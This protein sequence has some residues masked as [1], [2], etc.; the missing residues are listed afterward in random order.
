MQYKA[1]KIRIEPNNKQRG[2]FAQHAGVARHAYNQGL[3]YCNEL[4]EQGER[5]PSAFDL[6]KWLVR[7]VKQEHPWYYEVSSCSINQALK[8]LG[9]AFSNF[10]RLQKKSGYKLT[11]D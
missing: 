8:D 7:T 2:L 5:V 9:E 3:A 11:D 4:Y 6:Q 1:Y 10:H